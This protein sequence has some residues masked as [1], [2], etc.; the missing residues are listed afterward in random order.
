[1][2]EELP[3]YSLP[4]HKPRALLPKFIALTLLSVLFYIGILL[5][6][7]LLDLTGKE[8]TTIKTGSLIL[9]GFL[10]LLGIILAIHQ[11]AYITKFYKEGI[12]LK[13][14]KI[15]YNTITTT[16]K[17]EDFLDKIFK[18][19]SLN[20]GNHNHLR[21]IP[22]TIDIEQYLRQLQEYNQKRQSS[23]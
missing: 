13:G 6:V 9:V 23:I 11:A 14:K 15:V 20:L 8:E 21:H 17:N 2:P 1:M 5:N 3:L 10:F 16:T 7:A 19:H 12:S 18:T 22:N 4:Q